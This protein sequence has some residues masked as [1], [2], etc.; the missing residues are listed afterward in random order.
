MKKPS[1]TEP[2]VMTPTRVDVEVLFE[3]LSMRFAD[4]WRRRKKSK[5]PAAIRV[6]EGG[7]ADG[8]EDVELLVEEATRLKS[9]MMT[10]QNLLNDQRLAKMS[11]ELVDVALSL[12]F[13]F[14]DSRDSELLVLSSSIASSLATGTMSD[15]TKTYVDFGGDHRNRHTAV[16]GG[17]IRSYEDTGS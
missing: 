1:D 16:R 9:E 13:G 4:R 8:I 7:L 3:T 10:Y 11:A 17:L 12:L 6:A 2:K 5:V 14:T 15:E